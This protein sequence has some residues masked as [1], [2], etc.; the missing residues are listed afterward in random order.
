MF[1]LVNLLAKIIPNRTF[2]V[3]DEM[4]DD[5]NRLSWIKKDIEY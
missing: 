4:G 2:Q 1:S 5:V 3:G